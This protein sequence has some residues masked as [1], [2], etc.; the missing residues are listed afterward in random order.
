MASCACLLKGNSRNKTSRHARG[1]HYVSMINRS[2]MA[3]PRLP[4][5]TYGRSIDVMPT[6]WNFVNAFTS[7]LSDTS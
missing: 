6:A 5:P 3:A 2:A 1:D 7:S 4:G